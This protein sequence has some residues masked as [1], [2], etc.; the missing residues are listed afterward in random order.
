MSDHLFHAMIWLIVA[1]LCFLLAL[2]AIV[3][4]S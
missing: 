1:L 4:F 2:D 3:V